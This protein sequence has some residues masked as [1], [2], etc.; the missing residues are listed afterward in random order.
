MFV[1]SRVREIRKAVELSQKD[2][3]ARLGI[4]GAGIS[5][6]ESGQRGL[7]DQMILLICKEFN[8]NENWLRYG[9][10]GMLR[11][12]LPFGVEQ[13]AESYRLDELDKIIIS[14]YLMLDDKKRKVLKEYITRIA[15]YN[16]HSGVDLLDNGAN[17]QICA[18]EQPKDNF[19]TG[20]QYGKKKND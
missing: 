12:P 17:V 18:E 5:K 13:L 10:G 3:A 11:Q 14:E 2:F 8:I 15:G 9:E 6:I 4:T 7:T 16:T 19:K 20:L 1:N